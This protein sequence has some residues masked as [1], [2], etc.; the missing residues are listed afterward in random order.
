VG[1][2]A[3]M[4][5]VVLCVAAPVV[6]AIVIG[7][8][9]SLIALLPPVARFARRFP[10]ARMGIYAGLCG[11]AALSFLLLIGSL[12]ADLSLWN[13]EDSL[14]V[15]VENRTLKFE[16]GL[17]IIA[18]FAFEGHCISG[19]SEICKAVDRL[20]YW[21][22]DDPMD[23]VGP[24]IGYTMFVLFPGL[25]TALT[26]AWAVWRWTTPYQRDKALSR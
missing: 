17:R 8:L 9:L 12:L 24:W 7:F 19:K 18:P 2:E 5:V 25:I 4:I 11:L 26:T 16:A 20:D 23:A 10:L 1:A 22:S 14:P 13:Q 15:P 3:A 6:A 21:S